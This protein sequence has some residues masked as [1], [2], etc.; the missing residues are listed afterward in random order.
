MHIADVKTDR[1]IVIE[2]QHSFLHRNERES[3]EKFYQNMVWVVDGLDECETGLAFS[4][5]LQEL[6]SSKTNR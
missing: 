1:G 4:S 2:F 3:R 6:Q 5:C